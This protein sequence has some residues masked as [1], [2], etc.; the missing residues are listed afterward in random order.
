MI[1]KS[2]FY[3]LF[4]SFV[5]W[6]S[7]AFAHSVTGQ[8][9][10]KMSSFF[11]RLWQG[12]LLNHVLTGKSRMEASFEQ[13]ITGKLLKNPG[14]SRHFAPHIKKSCIIS[15]FAGLCADLVHISLRSYGVMFA[16]AGSI[17]AGATYLTGSGINFIFAAVAGL[18]MALML[19]NRSFAQLTAG[20]FVLQ[21]GITFFSVNLNDLTPRSANS[22]MLIF[23]GLGVIFGLSGYLFGLMGFIMAFGGLIGGLL[24]LWRVEVGIFAAAF[25]IPILPTMLILGLVAACIGSFLIKVLFTG[26]IK[27]TFK[28]IDVFVLLFS[29]LIAY[30]LVI[31]YSIESS[32]PVVLVYMLFVLFYF[33][34]KNTIN[35]KDK[36]MAVV[37]IIATSGL[38]V[39][40]F[41]IWQRITGNFVMT[42]AW[43]DADFFGTATVRIYST[44]ENPNVL[45]GYLIFIAILAFA[46]IYYYKDPLHKLMSLGIFGASSL[47]MVLTHSRGAWLGLMLAFAV[48]ALMRD[49]RL[50]AL[51]IIALLIAPLFIPPEILQRFL[52][53]GDMADTSTSYRVSIW[54]GAIDMLRVFWPI[55]IGQGVE[56][57]N[58]IY[59]MY[60][61]SAVHT[62]HSHNLYLQIMIY[63]GITGITLFLIIIGG[64]LKGLFRA[65]K[66]ASPRLKAIAA[67]LAAG[68]AGFL[69]KGLTDNVIYNFRVLAFFWVIIA[70][71]AALASLSCSRFKGS[72]SCD[73][74]PLATSQLWREKTRTSST[75]DLTNE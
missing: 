15:Y 74:P 46:M 6:L 42:Q 26:S 71:G 29:G 45:G 16:F 34:V 58:F 7:G 13:G 75:E 54:L 5:A 50:V 14:I 39:A 37:T 22:Y 25:F 68:M 63:W 60:A 32:R 70:L 10:A 31:T 57:F 52:S 30:G 64:F 35:T 55:G 33:V 19:I 20:S 23:A 12:S 66:N 1:E 11:G 43:L 18:G 2:W 36:L 17:S 40:L 49:R 62:Q 4:V 28:P 61:F 48:F 72:Q 38:F 69:L 73:Q 9:L 65:A 8:A 53:I 27:L 47:C 21:K 3:G 56:N 67:A 51:G 24:I 44:L 59:R 41:G